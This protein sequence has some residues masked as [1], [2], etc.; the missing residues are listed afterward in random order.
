MH[1]SILA[2]VGTAVAI[3]VSVLWSHDKVSGTKSL[4]V[5]DT[6]NQLIAQSCSDT[7][8]GPMSIDFSG[9]DE[10]GFGN[11]TVGTDSY[12]A[13][14]KVEYSGGIVCSKVYNEES[15]VVEC[16][17]IDWDPPA[18]PVVEADCHENAEV[19][20]LASHVSARSASPA[21]HLEERD[22]Q[23]VCTSSSSTELIGDGNPHQNYRHQQISENIF[24]GSSDT[25]TVGHEQSKTFT[26]GWT[27]EIS[28][29]GWIS[30][31]FEVQQSWT[32][33]NEYTCYA[34]T[35]ETGCVWYNLAHTAY[36]VHNHEYNSCVW[37]T[38]KYSDPFVMW[39]PNKNNRGG[40]YYCV[41]GTC[42]AQGDYYWDLNGRAGG[43]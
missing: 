27:S 3:D 28:A 9:V 33:G 35:G 42:R 39:S 15:A 18:D 21:S 12:L 2:L 37:P 17:D 25:C 23:I 29:D 13:H 20:D 36:T 26:V 40:G 38:N 43:P 6:S 7:I 16:H 34:H 22:P 10:N 1:L 31:G 5:S 14:S 8:E 24:C 30:G 19:D 11:V 4:R 32:S 41:I